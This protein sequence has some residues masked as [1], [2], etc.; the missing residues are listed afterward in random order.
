MFQIGG[1]GPMQGQANHFIRYAPEKIPYG[2]NDIPKK[3]KD[4]TPS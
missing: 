2:I 1:I 3:P 4:F